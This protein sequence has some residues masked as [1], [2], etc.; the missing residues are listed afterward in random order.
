[1]SI[2]VESPVEIDNEDRRPELHRVS[3]SIGDRRNSEILEHAV[4]H[5]IAVVVGTIHNEVAGG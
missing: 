5:A 2:D 3:R 1:V 4:N